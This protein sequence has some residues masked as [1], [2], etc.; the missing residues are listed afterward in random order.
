MLLISYTS[1]I[2]A[3]ENISWSESEIGII[4]SL[5]LHS[6]P[7]NPPLAPS[8]TLGNHNGAKDLGKSLF[9]DTGLSSNGKIS[10]A[11]CH[12]PELNFT[13]GRILGQGMETLTKNS[14]TLLGAAYQQWFY[15]DGRRDS[16]WAQAITP[17]ETLSEMAMTRVEVVKYILNDSVYR[18]L[19]EAIFGPV[20]FDIRLLPKKA[21]PFGDQIAKKNWRY[22]S[23]NLKHQINHIFANV[24][25]V[26]AAYER[27]LMPSAGRLELFLQKFKYNSTKND[28]NF[29]QNVLSRDEL[30]GLKLFID[31]KKTQCLRCHNGP[32][33]TNREF[34]NVGTATLS[35]KNLDLGRMIGLQAVFG[36]A[37]NCFGK[38]SGV[39]QD[40][41]TELQHVNTR[42]S[43]SA[44]L[45]AFKVPTLR[46]LSKTA[47]YGHNGQFATLDDMMQH[48]NEPPNKDVYNHELLPLNL[49]DDEIKQLVAFLKIL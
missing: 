43:H 30:L 24:G 20:T 48:Y 13:D 31:D 3:S 4:S 25:R 46:G 35:G 19:Y 10:C 27:D 33:L 18:P 16:L 40:S 37:F 14:P 15:I 34:H 5:S 29:Q 38:Y 1:S 44:L 45:G 36:D 12:N 39:R 17:I 41:C 21:G 28:D 6:F 9:F 8:N 2:K 11:T 47:P 42:D 23:P 22:L 32:L 7:E 49:S 26:I